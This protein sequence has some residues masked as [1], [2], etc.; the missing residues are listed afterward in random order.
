MNNRL[1]AALILFTVQAL[2][3]QNP[4]SLRV[5]IHQLKSEQYRWEDLKLVQGVGA[6]VHGKACAVKGDLKGAIV[7]FQKGVKKSKAA[8]YYNIGLTYFYMHNYP[9]AI[10]YFKKAE[11]IK[12]DAL[13]RSYRQT[14]A[15]KLKEKPNAMKK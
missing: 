15:R 2:A 8:A 5:G 12:P 7:E 14:A 11:R 1:V 3:A 4:D 10:Q 6:F 9:V 13:S